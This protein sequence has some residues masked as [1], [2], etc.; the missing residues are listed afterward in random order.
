[1]RN[2]NTQQYAMQLRK[3]LTDAERHLWQHLR[4]RQLGGHRFRRQ[5]PISSYI[6]DFAC[7]DAKLIIEVDGGQH[8]EEAA[9]DQQREWALKA[10]GYRVIRFWN[11][12]VFKETEAVLQVILDAL[13]ETPPS[14]PSPASEGRRQ[15]GSRP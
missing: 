5:V 1:M 3:Q 9:Y 11:D 2:A 15:D 8:V 13:N 12:A 7:L 4:L 6:A 14:R 10:L